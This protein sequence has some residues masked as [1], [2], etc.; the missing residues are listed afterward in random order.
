M[1]LHRPLPRR[2]QPHIDGDVTGSTEIGGIELADTFTSVVFAPTMRDLHQS[3]PFVLT[4]GLDVEEPSM[5][6]PGPDDVLLIPV[7]DDVME[8]T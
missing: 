1:T 8:I 4:P 2:I 5:V 7:P 6:V 3:P